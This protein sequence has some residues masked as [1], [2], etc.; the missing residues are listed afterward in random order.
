MRLQNLPRAWTRSARPRAARKASLCHAEVLLQDWCRSGS[1]LPSK[2]HFMGRMSHH[3]ARS[4]LKIHTMQRVL[5]FSYAVCLTPCCVSLVL[6]CVLYFPFSVSCTGK[7][8]TYSKTHS[9][10]IAR[11]TACESGKKHCME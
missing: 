9:M 3:Q 4:V 7:Y 5:L 11:R 10:Q 6:L 1:R 2:A 8:E